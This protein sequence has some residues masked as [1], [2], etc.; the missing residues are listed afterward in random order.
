MSEDPAAKP[1]ADWLKWS[2]WGV[3]A[4]GVAG[5]VYIMGQ[6]T[7]K[8]VETP[9][10]VAP[11]A[12]GAPAP[13]G[14]GFAD[15]L[16]VNNPPVAAFPQSFL[17]ASGKRVTMADFKGK[18]VVLNVWATWCGPCKVEMPTLAR[19]QAAYAGKPLAVVTVSV[20]KPEQLDQ[21]RAFIAA[22]APLAFYNDP[23]TNLPFE[24]DPP[25]V[26][27]PTTLIFDAGGR[28]RGRV[29]GEVDWAG[30]QAKAFLDL[31][32]AES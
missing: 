7:F 30:P 21:A 6:A 12:P 11:A 1:G 32:L 17:D 20:D 13:A 4:L 5:V 23:T 10:P 22:N 15:K 3:A 28:Q 31:L 26:G 24:I 25:A 9:A 2:L 29:G 19:L 16:E 18:V 8:R 14:K 27:M